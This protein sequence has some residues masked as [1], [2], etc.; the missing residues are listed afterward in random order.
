MNFVDSY[1][2]IRHKWSYHHQEIMDLLISLDLMRE[3]LSLMATSKG[4]FGALSNIPRY[5]DL[6]V[7]S[8]HARVERLM[9]SV[10]KH[11]DEMVMHATQTRRL[12]EEAEASPPA[13]PPSHGALRYASAEIVGGE[14]N[15]AT[16]EYHTLRS[17]AN[18]LLEATECCA[19]LLNK[20]PEACSFKD[21]AHSISIPEITGRWQDLVMQL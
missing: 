8:C 20:I 17:S 7:G 10:W 2:S 14:G 18:S 15:G 13:S 1:K 9:H 3:R 21:S 16:L 12:V 11:F 19:L 5:P 4:V 6:L